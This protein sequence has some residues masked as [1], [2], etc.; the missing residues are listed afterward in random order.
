MDAR[1]VCG[2]W[3]MVVKR[4][5]MGMMQHGVEMLPGRSALTMIIV[6]SGDTE[7][8]TSMA[9]MEVNIVLMKNDGNAKCSEGTTANVD[10][11]NTDEQ[12]R[13]A[14]LKI[15]SRISMMHLLSARDGDAVDCQNKTMMAL[16]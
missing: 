1:I 10:V 13:Y 5:L 16:F 4:E 12:K 8:L 3:K 6:D 11:C 15:D 9:M 7:Q 14:T 2:N